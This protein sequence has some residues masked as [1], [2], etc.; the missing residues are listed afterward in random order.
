MIHVYD[1]P[2]E[3]LKLLKQL[4]GTHD[5]EDSAICIVVFDVL[6]GQASFEKGK[7]IVSKVLDL[8]GVS[9]A[10]AGNKVDVIGEGTGNPAA[11]E[12]AS[13]EAFAQSKSIPFFAVSAKTNA[14]VERMFQTV[15]GVQKAPVQS[16]GTGLK[17]ARPQGGS[18]Y[19]KDMIN[20]KR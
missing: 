18:G 8:A 12:A 15:A 6:G 19:F 5:E 3:P 7:R 17:A 1:D 14:S 16:V 11:S 20:Q 2:S 10:I 13:L 9:V 4:A